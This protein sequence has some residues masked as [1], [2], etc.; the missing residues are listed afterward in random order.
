[1]PHPISKARQTQSARAALYLAAMPHAASPDGSGCP[2]GGEW[3]GRPACPAQVWGVC[4]G[5]LCGVFV[6]GNPGRGGL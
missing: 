5:R 6:Y 1:M 4:V 2:A 3:L